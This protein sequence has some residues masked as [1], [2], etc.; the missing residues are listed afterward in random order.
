MNIELNADASGQPRPD[1]RR[2]LKYA[3]GLGAAVVGIIA[4]T[5]TDAPRAYA[6]SC[7]NAGCCTLATFTPCGGHWDNDGN[8]S[9]PSGYRKVYWGCVQS[10]V[11]GY[12]C[13]ECFSGSGSCEN[14]SCGSRAYSCSNWY[15]YKI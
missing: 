6:A 8:F 7:Y 14:G 12:I 11:V 3:G 5:W 15:Q 1:R 13:W 9:C 10:A 4:G 2:F